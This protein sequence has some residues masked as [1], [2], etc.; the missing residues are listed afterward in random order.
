MDSVW[1]LVWIHPQ[2]HRTTRIAPLKACIH[3]NLIQSHLF[4]SPLDRTRAWYND[5]C[6]IGSDVLTSDKLSCQ[7]Q[8]AE[9]GIGAGA[10]KDIT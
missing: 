6:Q 3:E 2:A 7:L 10:D 1:H 8:V 9:P 4:S 5:S